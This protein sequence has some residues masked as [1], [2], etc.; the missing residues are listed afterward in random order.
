MMKNR[1]IATGTRVCHYPCDKIRV[2]SS[3]DEVDARVWLLFQKSTPSVKQW[4]SLEAATT[5]KSSAQSVKWK[6][7]ETQGAPAKAKAIDGDGAWSMD[8]DISIDA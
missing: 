6:G 2:E 5:P 1:N 8:R 3:R 7:N 4:G